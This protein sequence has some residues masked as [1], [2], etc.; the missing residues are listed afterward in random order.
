MERS[1]SD[2]QPTLF[3]RPI[4]RRDL[5][6]LTGKVLAGGALAGMW[7]S[8][9]L[10]SY[11][12]AAATGRASGGSVSVMSQYSPPGPGKWKSYFAAFT[13]ETGITVNLEDVVYNNQYQKIATQGQGG[14]AGYDVVAIDTIWSGSF[15]GAGFTLDLSNFLP[16]AVQKQIAPAA[17]SSVSYKGKMY[18][19]PAYNSSKHFYY[20]KTMLSQVGLHRPPAT[21][22]EMVSYCEILKRNKAKLG[23][24]YPMSAPWA[25]AENLTCDFVDLVGATGGRFYASDNATPNFDKTSGVQTLQ[26]MKMLLDKGYMAPG[27][28]T[29]TGGETEDDLLGG[30]TV[31]CTRWEGVMAD[32]RNPA[33]A[34]ASVRGNIR[35]ALIPG[36]AGHKSGAC[37]GPEGWAIMKSSTHQTEAK[38]FLNW[39]VSRSAQKQGMVMF[40]QFPIY[41]SMYADPE[42]RQL[43]KKADGVDDFALYGEQFNYAQARPNFP[44]Y[45]A[46]SGRLQANL[47]KGL[48]GQETARKAIDAA[49]AEMKTAVGSGSN[50]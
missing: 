13:R 14:V 27:S 49:A 38:A 26:L 24:Q 16:P 31:M 3:G 4:D 22:T 10:A 23:I 37:L 19:V 21:L 41:S 40:D 5:L 32:S 20:N 36:S 28:L 30:K 9:E 6:K 12:E 15:G 29:H 18:G 11:V 17:L 48:L 7:L 39:W 33:L 43:A 35:L 45:L 50:P 47:Q 8:P 2:D 44:G 46:A 1:M 25:Q 42:L 34:V